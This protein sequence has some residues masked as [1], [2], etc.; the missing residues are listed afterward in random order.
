M[1]SLKHDQ[2]VAVMRA[3]LKLPIEQRTV[4][5]H[6]I[7]TR[8][9]MYISRFTDTN[10][11]RAVRVVLR[12]IMVRLALQGVAQHLGGLSGDLIRCSMLPS[13]WAP[14]S[15][16]EFEMCFVVTNSAGQKLAYVCF[17]EEPGRQSP[18]KLLT[19]DEARR[20][21]AN[22]AKLPE[23]LLRGP[24]PGQDCR[25]PEPALGGGYHLHRHRD[26]L[27]LSGSSP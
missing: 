8:L 23:L 5:L 15:V 13:A 17:E 26:G 7:A 25:W 24:H 19:K 22:I 21:A 2:L 20:V 3:V 11:D 4:L 27:R 18:S 12:E 9:P 10:L 1:S 16:K 14:W 6:H